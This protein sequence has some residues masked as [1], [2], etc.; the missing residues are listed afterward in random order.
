L[1]NFT[2]DKINV[3]KF[4]SAFKRRMNHEPTSKIFNKKEFWSLDF[5]VN[6]FVLDP[7]PESEFLIQTISEYFTDLQSNIKICDQKNIFLRE[8]ILNMQK[9]F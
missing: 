9:T 2:K 3:R 5:D 1:N 4:Q 6:Q 8:V 7:R